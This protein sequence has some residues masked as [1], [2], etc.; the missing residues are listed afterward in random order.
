MS[1][2]KH[3][4]HAVKGTALV[5]AGAV[6]SNLLWFLSKVLIVRTTTK[7][8]FGIYS[9]VL[10]I[11][12][13]GTMLMLLGLPGGVAR[14]IPLY[15]GQ[16]RKEDAHHISRAAV[17]IGAATGTGAFLLLYALAG[18][19]QEQVFYIPGL[20]GPLRA[21]SVLFP[22]SVLL[23]I[24]SAVLQG[25]GLVLQ[26]FL[27][28]TFRPLALLALV[29]LS[30]ALGL[31]LEGVVYAFV[32][33]GVL[34]FL[35]VA[36]YGLRKVGAGPLLPGG[37]Y[38]GKLLRFS[39]LLMVAG[40][41]HT[42][43]LWTDTLMLG[44]YGSAADVGAYNVSTSLARLVMFPLAA[45]AFVFMPIAGRLFASGKMQE[46]KRAYQVL[47][48]WVFSATLPILFVLLF[49]PAI[50]IS[51]L[52]G[53]GFSEAIAPLRLLC[54][55]FT[56]HVFLGTNIMLLTVLGLPHIVMMNSAGAAL[57]NVVLNYIFIKLLG[58]G[59]KGAALASMVSYI[60]ANLIASF[61]LYRRSG[62]HPLT[63]QYLKPVLSSALVGLAIYALAK[64]LPFQL[65]ILPLHLVLFLG[66]YFWALLLTR[67]LEAEDLDL[68]KAISERTGIQTEWLRRCIGRFVA[69]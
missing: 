54:L 69:R 18:L 16:D 4:G 41:A 14:H 27:E 66:G 5:M 6:T 15:L 55:G 63:P 68:L 56:V 59:L 53:E 64:A 61:I 12:S 50:A 38:Y 48:K 1:L 3:L 10:A 13:M 23:A 17:T 11:L 49:F 24:F 31:G 2:R 46:L 45:L 57:L 42:V 25:H 34:T 9:L 47:T 29:A 22:F 33:S 67:S 19:L 62:L 21:A 28:D 26:R 30:V 51:F 8:E 35:L 20:A 43:L 32:G 36:A 60:Q 40:V 52:F 37:R 39:V 44:R 65:W 7:E 58:L